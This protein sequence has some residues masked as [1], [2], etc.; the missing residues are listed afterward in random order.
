M[1]TR[2]YSF[3]KP[4]QHVNLLTKA[5]THKHKPAYLSSLISSDLL[6]RNDTAATLISQ[7]ACGTT[8]V[9]SRAATGLI[10]PSD[11]PLLIHF[12]FF[13]AS[14]FFIFSTSWSLHSK[15]SGRGQGHCLDVYVVLHAHRVACGH[16][17]FFPTR[18][19]GC[20]CLC[21]GACVF[22]SLDSWFWGWRGGGGWRGRLKLGEGMWG[23]FTCV[24]KREMVY[25]VGVGG[26]NDIDGRDND[27][28]QL[29]L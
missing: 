16:V 10:K 21:E 7:S 24:G 17:F 11:R 19:Y 6:T 9:L 4:W 14:S 28:I 25:I 18:V 1:F 15:E 26:V 22:G 12:L 3:R 20:M 2:F 23:L 29:C 8:Q 13:N 27:S 5:G